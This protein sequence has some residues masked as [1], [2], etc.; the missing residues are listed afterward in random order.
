MANTK[1]F[2]DSD[3]KLARPHKV[4]KVVDRWLSARDGGGR[5]GPALPSRPGP[6]R[7][8]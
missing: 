2:D 3:R 1:A 6:G 8:A 5:S 4:G 7:S